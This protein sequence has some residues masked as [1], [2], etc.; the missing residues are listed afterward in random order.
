MATSILASRLP[1]GQ[2]LQH[3]PFVPIENTRLLRIKFCHEG[4]RLS[5]YLV[6]GKHLHRI[7][8]SRKRRHCQICTGCPANL[9]PLLFFEFLG[10]LE[11]QKFHLGH[12]STALF[13][14]ILKISN[15][16]F[17]GEKWTKILAK[18]YKEVILKFN[19]FCFMFN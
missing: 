5:M 4:L 3:R 11:V 19:I 14:Q 16:L 15:F 7:F 13:V 10:F 6:G 8:H 12:F 9:F 2:R 17:F 1:N 18:Y